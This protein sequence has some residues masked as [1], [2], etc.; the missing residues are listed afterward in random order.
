MFTDCYCT[1]FR[2]AS[3]GLTRVYDAALKPVGLRI[4]QFS[5]LRSLGRLGE[6]TSTQVAAE[7]SLDRTTISRNVK[8]LIDAGWVDVIEDG[9]SGRERPMRLNPAG[10]RKIAE[11]LPYFND[12]QKMVEQGIGAFL[13]SPSDDR[14]MQALVNLQQFAGEALDPA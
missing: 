10:Q 2:R 8:L 3:H 11:A 14:L 4:T 5:L 12:A 13:S 1:Q 7:L 9:S 6:A